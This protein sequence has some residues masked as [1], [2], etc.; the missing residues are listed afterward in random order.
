LPFRQNL[1]QRPWQTSPLLA[2]HC[3]HGLAFAL[4]PP[5]D[6]AFLEITKDALLCR[7]VEGDPGGQCG[8]HKYRDRVS[9][10]DEIGVRPEIHVASAN[11]CACSNRML[12]TRRRRISLRM[13]ANRR[14]TNSSVKGNAMIR[15]GAS[16]DG[17]IVGPPMR[18]TEAGWCSVFH[19]STENLM[20]GR[21][22][23]PTRD[24]IAAARASRP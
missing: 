4:R 8:H 17:S 15:S 14:V 9:G 19:Q 23:A 18:N 3:A 7:I 21:L 22:T 5:G 10:D 1:K 12:R 2:R 6:S 13:L 16:N 20:I 11:S 24:R